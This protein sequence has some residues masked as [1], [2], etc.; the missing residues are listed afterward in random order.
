VTR[1]TL[2]LAAALAVAALAAGCDPHLIAQSLPPPGRTGNLDPVDGF[3]TIKYY[4]ATLSSGT[5]LAITCEHGGPCQDLQ[6][7]SLDPDVAQVVPAS[8]SRL[9][10]AG[11][12]AN[13]P[14]ASFLIVGK[15]AGKTTVR[16]KARSGSRRIDVTVVPVPA[17]AAVVAR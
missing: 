13:R 7:R 5:A 17:P 1:T 11:A 12:A 2:A 15:R 4:E 10:P 8:L 9:D 14:A 16:V 6:I 3:W